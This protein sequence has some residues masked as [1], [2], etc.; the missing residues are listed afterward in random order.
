MEVEN[1]GVVSDLSF[2]TP[3]TDLNAPGFDVSFNSIE[4]HSFKAE[5]KASE[6]CEYYYL[7]QEKKYY[8]TCLKI[9]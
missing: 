3:V 8:T 7:M 9:N 5:V 2:T 1:Q 4:N 6:S